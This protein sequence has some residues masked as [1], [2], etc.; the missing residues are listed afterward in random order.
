MFVFIMDLFWTV[1]SILVAPTPLLITIVDT[2][3]LE[4][5]TVNALTYGQRMRD[6]PENNGKKTERIRNNL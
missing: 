6:F 5:A 4:R 1:T 2:I 3:F